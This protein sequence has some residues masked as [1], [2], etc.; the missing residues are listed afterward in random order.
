MCTWVPMIHTGT[1]HGHAGHPDAR[2]CGR[3]IGAMLPGSCHTLHSRPTLWNGDSPSQPLAKTAKSSPQYISERGGAENMAGIDR[4][5][6]AIIRR[7]RRSIQI[8][9]LV[10]I[11]MVDIID[12]DIYIYIYIYVYTYIKVQ[13]VYSYMYDWSRPLSRAP[14]KAG[15]PDPGARA[16]ELARPWCGVVW[17]GVV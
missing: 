1:W 8:S 10:L 16:A 12:I 7:R 17:C 11:I 9:I 14:T 6:Q 3:Y 2:R 5:H 13:D 4:S 15:P